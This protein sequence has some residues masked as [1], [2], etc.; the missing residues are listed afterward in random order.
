MGDGAAP[1]RQ[2]DKHRVWYGDTLLLH[3][4]QAEGDQYGLG[5]SIPHQFAQKK[6][7]R[8]FVIKQQLTENSECTDIPL[9][10]SRRAVAMSLAEQTQLE[11]EGLDC[12]WMS[13][14]K[15]T[16]GNQ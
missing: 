10:K 7:D 2:R 4:Q 8:G 11:G 14:G 16:Q 15:E 3:N 1:S 6:P 5:N 13:D 12:A 9:E